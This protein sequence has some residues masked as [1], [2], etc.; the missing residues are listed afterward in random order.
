[1]LRL[2]I[3]VNNYITQ[4]VSTYFVPICTLLFLGALCSVLGAALLTVSNTLSIECTT[5]NVITYTGQVTNTSTTDKNNRVLLKVVTDT[6]DVGS[7]FHSVG[8]SYSCNLTK[9]GV[10]LLGSCSSNLG[11]NASSL[12]CSLVDRL[13][14]KS[15]EALLESGCLRLRNLILTTLSYELVKGWHD[16]PPSLND[17]V[18]Y[19]SHASTIYIIA[20]HPNSYWLRA[21]RHNSPRHT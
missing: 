10:R 7:S 17:I 9:R 8:K 18:F 11:A 4:H 20:M 14:S 16:F 21:K 6:G 19:Y 5:N 3:L 2:A 12:R 1:M 13:I 15:V